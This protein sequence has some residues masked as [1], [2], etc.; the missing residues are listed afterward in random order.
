MTFDPGLRVKCAICGDIGH[1]EC[2]LQLLSDPPIE[3]EHM[4]PTCIKAV[5]DATEQRKKSYKRK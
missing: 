3:E 5:E 1:W 2:T 4:C